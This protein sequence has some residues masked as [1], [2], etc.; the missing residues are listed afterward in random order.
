MKHVD[1]TNLDLYHIILETLVKEGGVLLKCLKLLPLNFC[2]TGNVWVER[3]WQVCHWHDE[4]DRE[5]G[6]YLLPPSNLNNNNNNISFVSHG[7]QKRWCVC[8]LTPYLVEIERLFLMDFSF[9]WKN[10]EKLSVNISITVSSI[11]NATNGN[12]VKYCPGGIFEESE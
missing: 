8:R 4:Q 11:V 5:T 3:T 6:P 7:V 9:I 2:S 1:Q 10:A 12:M